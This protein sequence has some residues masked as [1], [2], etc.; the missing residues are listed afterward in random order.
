MKK[1]VVLLLFSLVAAC[2]PYKSTL[3]KDIPP[4]PQ[5]FKYSLEE[6]QES[7]G[8]WWESFNDS[9]LNKLMNTMFENSPSIAQA[10]EN[11]K[12]YEA[13]FNKTGADR[14]LKLT[15]SGGVSRNYNSS[16]LPGEK[17]YTTY[18][19]STAASFELDVWNRLKNSAKAS[20]LD[21]MASKYDLEGTYISL[22]ANLADTYF[23]LAERRKRMELLKKQIAVSE[24][25]MSSYLD[26]Y[27]S[28]VADFETMLSMYTSHNTL[29]SSVNDLQKDI[30]TA[31]NAIAL[32]IGSTPAEVDRIT[33][34]S[35]DIIPP[36]LPVNSP[37]DIINK[38]PDLKSAFQD[39]QSADL[40]VAS[41]VAARFPTLS[42]GQTVYNAAASTDLLFNPMWHLVSIFVDAGLSVIDGGAKKAEVE[43]KKHTLKQQIYA[44]KSTVLT[45]VKEVEDA[46]VKNIEYEKKVKIIEGIVE[47]N[48]KLM[49]LSEDRYASGLIKY[50]ELMS[51]LQEYYSS[52]MDLNFAKRQLIS[53]RIELAR[54][55]GGSWPEEYV[56]GEKK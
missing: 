37:V 8:K 9:A 47:A 1:I 38:R 48:T 50:A 19:F 28:G 15:V 35:M 52:L 53:S 22:T 17:Y 5:K 13:T 54:V 45:A 46:M 33:S 12:K 41:A 34:G 32:L 36:A 27:E 40:R 11:W 2:T 21:A 39:I 49:R 55:I 23:M 24:S 30:L 25:R 7:K 51:V 14:R 29:K 16:K 4:N 31:E 42:L 56:K 26:L 3:E 20:Y 43:I 10:V 18:D 6:T 44:Y